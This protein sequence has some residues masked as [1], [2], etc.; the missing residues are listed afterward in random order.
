MH[1]MWMASVNVDVIV[2]RGGGEGDES[3]KHQICKAQAS[4]HPKCVSNW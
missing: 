2:E 1:G 4:D 3:A